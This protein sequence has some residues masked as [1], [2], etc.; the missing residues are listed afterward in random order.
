MKQNFISILM[1]TV[2]VAITAYAA[3]EVRKPVCPL[4]I[5][6]NGDGIAVS[7]TRQVKFDLLGNGKPVSIA[8]PMGAD[9]AQL[10]FD[11]DGNGR[12][13]G[14]AELFGGKS[15]GFAALR[16]EDSN[17][18]NMIDAADANFGKLALWFDANH[19]A[20]TDDGELRPLA[21]FVAAIPLKAAKANEP[22]GPLAFIGAVGSAVT[23]AGQAV[24]IFDVYYDVE[25]PASGS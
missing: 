17:G 3:T 23:P 14:I 19:D 15:G 12:I 9:D 24:N 11:R 20:I 8:W 18:D 25:H 16:K 13:D 5:D 4:T 22:L 21:E 2:F 10:A 1:V 7:A 6:L